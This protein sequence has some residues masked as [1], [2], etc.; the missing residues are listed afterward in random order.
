MPI[1]TPDSELLVDLMRI[2]KENNLIRISTTQYEDLGGK[3][4]SSTFTERMPWNKW[5]R[6]AKLQ[7]VSESNIPKWK[8]IR[9]G[10]RIAKKLKKNSMTGDEYVDNGGHSLT[11]IYS[12]FESWNKF[13][14]ACGLDLVLRRG[15]TKQDIVEDIWR[16]NQEA[17]IKPISSTYYTKRGKFPRTTVHRY[18]GKWSLVLEAVDEFD[19]NLKPI[20]SILQS[21]HALKIEKM[22]VPIAPRLIKPKFKIKIPKVRK[23]QK[24]VFDP[25]LN[26]LVKISKKPIVEQKE[27]IEIKIIIIGNSSD[28]L[29]RA[30]IEEDKVKKFFHV[31]EK[32]SP[33]Y[34]E[35]F[36]WVG[37]F[38]ND[39][40]SVKLN[41]NLYQIDRTGQKIKSTSGRTPTSYI[42]DSDSKY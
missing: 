21:I 3:F 9:S 2:A 42:S 17:S 14:I 8:M 1:R 11:T 30:F 31:N 5:L 6:K 34:G 18:L 20:F 15:I 10:K 27:K 29:R 39:K 22:D 37:D 33:A 4:S 41:G 24:K 16:I 32:G 26:N 12:K 13:L 19:K 40:A 35:R 38:F 25:E 23:K 36:E 7:L 28:G